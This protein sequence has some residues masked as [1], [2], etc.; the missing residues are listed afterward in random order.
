M[1]R[2]LI[3]DKTR[4][5]G[6]HSLLDR[7]V[8]DV[9]PALTAE[10]E[11]PTLTPEKESPTLRAQSETD[12]SLTTLCQFLQSAF[13]LTLPIECRHLSPLTPSLTTLS[14]A[15]NQAAMLLTE[16]M[17]VLDVLHAAQFVRFARYPHSQLHSAPLDFIST[18]H[19]QL[20]ANT[21]F[22]EFVAAPHLVAE[23]A[24][25]LQEAL[26]PAYARP[27]DGAD[28][29][30]ALCERLAERC[31]GYFS[32]VEK[33]VQE[34]A[35][36]LHLR[37][38][39]ANETDFA[40]EKLELAIASCLREELPVTR[41]RVE[42]LLAPRP[43]VLV[44]VLLRGSKL[45]QTTRMIA[46]EDTC[47]ESGRSALAA[48][49]AALE[50]AVMAALETN[51]ESGSLKEM[52]D[53]VCAE[54]SVALKKR[55]LR[56]LVDGGQRVVV[57][58]LDEAAAELFLRGG[59]Y[60]LLHDVYVAH[61][62]LMKAATL[63]FEVC[64]MC[65]VPSERDM[66]ITE[67]AEMTATETAATGTTAMTTN[68]PLTLQ[69]R[70]EGLAMC[71]RDLE[72]LERSGSLERAPYAEMAAP[73]LRALLKTVELQQQLH[74]VKAVE[75]IEPVE[76]VQEECVRQRRF[77]LALE[78][79]VL[80]GDSTAESVRAC[81]ESFISER[82]GSL[83][84]AEA[85]V[86]SVVALMKTV[87]EPAFLPLQTILS[88]LVQLGLPRES[89][90]ALL[91]GVAEAGVRSAEVPT[92]L[93]GLLD[94]TAEERGRVAV[95]ALIETWVKGLSTEERASEAVRYLVEMTCARLASVVELREEAE[96]V[97]RGLLE[98]W[99]VCWNCNAF[100]RLVA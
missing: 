21:P 42:A 57:L 69:E 91:V 56:W 49:Q 8:W 75:A 47:V 36:L 78:C 50:E 23:L 11:S 89:Q 9:S 77:D 19:R 6:A 98:L 100:D 55:V 44:R 37:G 68:T 24:P 41:Q 39:S 76:A 67:T 25:V 22:I 79:L 3:V 51:R 31:G 5:F 61:G 35:F 1:I 81:W 34:A 20:L 15:Q 4:P 80:R 18:D 94:A 72:D 92:L 48:E 62:H 82:A 59:D 65:V 96:R 27:W 38:L 46:V 26:V 99:R 90:T 97:C 2:R 87:K 16:A 64:V 84:C 73:R 66:T 83:G 63:L 45:L 95:G 13:H 88:C 70:H 71:L 32:A 33:L 60:A 74:G 53:V 54:G 52:C 58:Q 93:L 40:A 14:P 10:K 86:A 17:R 43:V 30:E 12:H 7:A 85:V 28:G 29:F